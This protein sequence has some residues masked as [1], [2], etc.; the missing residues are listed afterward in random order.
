M[1]NPNKHSSI[2]ALTQDELERSAKADRAGFAYADTNPA[3]VFGPNTGRLG[4]EIRTV[5]PRRYRQLKHEYLVQ[6]GQVK[7]DPIEF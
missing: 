4:T 1:N 6:T 5:N 2:D 3:A 7:A